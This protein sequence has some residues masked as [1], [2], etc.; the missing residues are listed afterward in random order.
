M[1]SPAML[2]IN[3]SLTNEDDHHGVGGGGVLCMSLF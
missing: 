1:L 2:N 3:I